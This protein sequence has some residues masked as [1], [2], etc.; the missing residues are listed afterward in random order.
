MPVTQKVS[1]SGIVAVELTGHLTKAALVG[2][3]DAADA[4]LASTAERI[5][6]LVDCSKMTSY[7]TEAREHFVEWNKGARARVRRLAVVTER[8]MWQLVVSGMALASGQ[9]MKAFDDRYSA[10][11]WLSSH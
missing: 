11:R 6:L 1:A 7:D 9:A 3:L 4:A 10:E 8:A 2:A 5:A